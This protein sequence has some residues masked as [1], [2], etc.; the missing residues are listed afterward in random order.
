MTKTAGV[1]L[2]LMGVILM[3]AKPVLATNMILGSDVRT[4]PDVPCGTEDTYWLREWSGSLNGVFTVD[5]PTCESPGGTGI[6][7]MAS[8]SGTWSLYATSPSGV[9]H[10]ST[11]IDVKGG[12]TGQIGC[13]T[14][15]QVG[16][17]SPGV[18]I[19][20]GTIEPGL[21]RITIEGQA[22]DLNLQVFEDMASRDW[23]RLNCPVQDWSAGA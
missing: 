17:F 6:R 2:I 5:V 8:G 3:A 4:G 21:W 22:K 7:F 10:S 15:P 16:E 23:Q 9:R 13:V 18:W 11:P 20:I 1:A 12:W 19:I 14:P